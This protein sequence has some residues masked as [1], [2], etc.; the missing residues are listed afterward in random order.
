MFKKNTK[1]KVVDL[2]GRE[3]SDTLKLWDRYK[4]KAFLWRAFALLQMPITT[5]LILASM[6]FFVTADTVLNIPLDPEPG[7]YSVKKL[8]DSLFVSHATNVVN[9]ISTYQPFTARKQYTTAVRYLWEPALSSFQKTHIDTDIEAVE[10]TSRSQLF[11]IDPKRVRVERIKN[12][13]VVKLPGTRQKFIHNKPLP[14]EQVAYFIK[15]TTIP[16]NV[17]NEYGIVVT[18]LQLK[19]VKKSEPTDTKQVK[20]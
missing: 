14:P 1:E 17:H 15:M 19:G 8:P 12:Y 13:V 7:S 2:P 10:E 5:V 11:F 6:I 18:D 3:A 16:R 20:G 4:E 9:L